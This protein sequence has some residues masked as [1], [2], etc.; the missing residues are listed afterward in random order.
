MLL[1]VIAAKLTLLRLYPM[2]VP[3]WDQ[4][5]GEAANLYLPYSNGGLTWRQMFTLHNEHRIFFTRVLAVVLLALNGQWDPQ[6]Q[7]VVNIGLHAVTAVVLTASLWLAAGRR[8]LAGSR[9]PWLWPWPRRSPSRTPWPAFSRPSTSCVLFS[10]LALWLMGAHRAGTGSWI[11]GW[12]C[13]LAAVVTV[14]GGLLTVVAIAV[15]V[16]PASHGWRSR[17]RGVRWW[18]R[19]PRRRVVAAVGV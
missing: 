2:P 4:W 13:A 17:E 7:I 16:T 3:F 6:L 10:L 14:A 12:A 15:G 18:P 8:W 1:I 11:V 9:S 19:R 5:D